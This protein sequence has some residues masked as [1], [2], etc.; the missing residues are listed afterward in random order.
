MLKN[1]FNQYTCVQNA[2]HLHT[3]IPF[4]IKCVPGLQPFCILP[5]Q[6]KEW[7]CMH[8]HILGSYSRREEKYSFVITKTLF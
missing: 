1:P 2:Q 3:Q 5:F 6:A 7:K 4:P 8:S